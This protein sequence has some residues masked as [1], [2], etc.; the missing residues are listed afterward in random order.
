MT[1]PNEEPKKPFYGEDGMHPMM[2]FCLDQDAARLKEE[3]RSLDD[4]EN[5][6]AE[7]RVYRMLPHHYAEKGWHP[8]EDKVAKRLLN[9]LLRRGYVNKLRDGSYVRRRRNKVQVAPNA[10]GI[11]NPE[12]L[13][14]H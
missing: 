1:E 6:I 2:A 7:I 11:S 14:R 10:R 8:G 13:P 9:R 3:G 5:T 4:R 12:R